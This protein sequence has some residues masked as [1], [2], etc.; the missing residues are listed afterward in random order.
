[1]VARAACVY[2]RRPAAVT[3]YYTFFI[4]VSIMIFIGFGYL[5]TFLKRYGYSAVGYNFL[6]SA[7]VFMWN[8]L[9]RVRS[10]R[11][12]HSCTPAPTVVVAAVCAW[13]PALRAHRS[14][15]GGDGSMVA[16]APDSPPRSPPRPIPFAPCAFEYTAVCLPSQCAGFWHNV[17]LKSSSFKIPLTFPLMFEGQCLPRVS[18]CPLP[19]PSFPPPL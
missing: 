13:G 14:R 11:A 18:V 10:R 17:Y 12:A 1:M 7:F 9:V 2:G 8:V 5:M 4:H 19:F 15:E 3:R 6:L 16:R